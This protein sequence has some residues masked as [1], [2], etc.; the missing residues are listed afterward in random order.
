MSN[1]TTRRNVITGA[2]ALP[3]LPASA[4]A[5]ETS[6]DAEL[7]RLG[8]ELDRAWA[9][10]KALIYDD[11]ACGDGYEVA[12]DASSAVGRQIEKQQAHTLEGLR[13]KA[14]AVMWCHQGEEMDGEPFTLSDQGTTDVRLVEALIRDLVEMP[15]A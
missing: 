5:T 4:L 7:L 9:Q 11:G 8:A 6:A 10:E 2:A 13:V 15:I 12:N 14:R 3:L 1:Q